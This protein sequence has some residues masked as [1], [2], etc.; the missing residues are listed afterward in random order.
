MDE[1][2]KAM[3]RAGEIQAAAEAAGQLAKAA[4]VECID[5]TLTDDN[6]RI[7]AMITACTAMYADAL[8]L[9]TASGE[10]YCQYTPEDGEVRL[11]AGLLSH[12][13]KPRIGALTELMRNLAE[14]GNNA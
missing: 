12:V 13:L 1:H 4:M 7:A 14:K 2:E 5:S 11:C 9:V 6:Q 8:D 3:R 10:A